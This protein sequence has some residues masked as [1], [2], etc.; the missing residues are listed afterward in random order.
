MIV[1]EVNCAMKYINHFVNPE[2][3]VEHSQLSTSDKKIIDKSVETINSWNNL[4][5]HR[6]SIVLGN[7]TDVKYL[8]QTNI[9]LK[10][11]KVQLSLLT[12][13]L[14]TKLSLLTRTN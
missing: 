3:Q 11:K 7:N 8:T 5:E 14:R 12:S 6:V 10:Q 2:Y 13:T 4:S 1:D 9:N